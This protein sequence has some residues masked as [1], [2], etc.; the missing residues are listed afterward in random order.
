M[1]PMSV[2]RKTAQKVREHML[3]SSFRHAH[4]RFIKKMPYRISEIVR[5]QDLDARGCFLQRAN[6]LHRRRSDA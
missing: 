5:G 3:E 1:A 6:R 2:S 4:A